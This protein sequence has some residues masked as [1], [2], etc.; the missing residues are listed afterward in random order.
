M[1]FH[2]RHQFTK[3][4]HVPRALKIEGVDSQTLAKVLGIEHSGPNL[5]IGRV[6]GLDPETPPFSVVY[7]ESTRYVPFLKSKQL[8]V[9]TTPQMADLVPHSCARLVSNSSPKEM[10]A[11]TA[12][13]VSTACERLPSYISHQAKVHHSAVIGDQ[14]FIDEY[15]EIEAGAVVNGPT[16]IGRHSRIGPNSVIGSEG[17]EVSRSVSGARIVKHLGGVWIDDFVTIRALCTID[18][19]LSGNFT[20]V[21]QRTM[22]DNLV[23]I[24]HGAEIMQ[25]CTIVAGAEI[26]GSTRLG[27]GVWMG[28]QSAVINGVSVGSHAMLGIG[29]IARRSVAPHTVLVG[30]HLVIGWRCKCGISSLLSE[31]RSACECGQ[32]APHWSRTSSEV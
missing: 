13:E 12:L 28:P 25:D 21:G 26:S 17:F 18:K 2:P 22:V 29:A 10:W 5:E 15:A 11:N 19:G 7:L 1:N 14:V 20:F 31:Q 32:A 3:Q 30:S 23:H 27:E 8:I 9:L 24:A 6:M 16:Y 4:N